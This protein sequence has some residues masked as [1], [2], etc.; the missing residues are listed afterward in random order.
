MPRW[1]SRSHPRTDSTCRTSESTPTAT[2]LAEIALPLA[3]AAIASRLNAPF[4]EADLDPA[5]T[6]WLD[7]PGAAFV[8]L[9]TDGRLHG[10]IGSVTPR[11]SLRDDIVDNARAAALRDRRF[12]RL[13]AQELGRTRI[14]VSVL[15]E[16]TPLPVTD[17]LEARARLRPG[18]DGV[19]LE[20]GGRRGV[21]LPQVWEQLPEPADFL[22]RLKVKAGLPAD[23]WGSDI[24][25]H[26]FTVLEAH[27]GQ[28][29][30]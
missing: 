14:E 16:P 25:L 29:T 22:G 21:F 8:T 23:Y 24:R 4:D 20:C 30:R 12:P 17:E 3:R 27:E 28:V 9:Q 26:R 5:P 10:C 13:T 19:V 2:Q 11:R 15:T 7:A 6:A 1:P 18:V